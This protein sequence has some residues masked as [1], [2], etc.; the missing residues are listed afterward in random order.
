M[1]NLLESGKDSAKKKLPNQTKFYF[2]QDYLE[3]K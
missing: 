3:V 1:Q 2:E